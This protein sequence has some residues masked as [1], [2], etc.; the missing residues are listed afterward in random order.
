MDGASLP[1]SVNC[2]NRLKVSVS[3]LTLVIPRSYIVRI[4]SVCGYEP[5]IVPEPH[6]ER[7]SRRLCSLRTAKN[8]RPKIGGNNE[9]K[10]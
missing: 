4:I 5:S 6:F 8:Y 9:K 7:E 1:L 2:E 10:C 3:T